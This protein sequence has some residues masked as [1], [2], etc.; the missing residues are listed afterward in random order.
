MDPTLRVDLLESSRQVKYE[1]SSRNIF[2]PYQPPPPPAPPAVKAPPPAAPPPQFPAAP[3]VTIPLKFYGIAERPTG[4]PKKALLT[5]GEEIFI[6]QEGD[7]VARY[8]RIIRI[9]LNT[10]QLEDTRDHKSHQL[11]LLEE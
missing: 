5:D 4:G 8:Y 11:P 10:I 3:A 9:G 6:A 2:E 7:L 1:G